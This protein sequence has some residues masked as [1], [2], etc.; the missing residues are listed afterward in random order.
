MK[1][2]K[3]KL[4]MMG[5]KVFIEEKKDSSFRIIFLML[6]FRG[7]YLQIRKSL[8]LF[9]LVYCLLFEFHLEFKSIP[10]KI[11]FPVF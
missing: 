4:L 2:V 9:T 11:F 5:I 8:F 6:I 7:I 1:M 10:S 3:V